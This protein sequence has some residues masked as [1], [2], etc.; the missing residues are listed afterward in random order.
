VDTNAWIVKLD[1]GLV[2]KLK[3][4]N[5][6]GLGVVTVSGLLLGKDGSI[7]AAGETETNPSPESTKKRQKTEALLDT[8]STILSRDDNVALPILETIPPTVTL[9]AKTVAQPFHVGD[10]R[11]TDLRRAMQSAGHTAEF[12][13]EGI[14]LVD[15]TVAVRKSTTGRVEVESVGLPV[16]DGGVPQMG[17][18]GTFYAVRKVIYDG[19]AV[20]AGA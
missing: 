16:V 7:E 9:S 18:G 17:M 4:Q 2:K 10:I 3:W 12:R 11:L 20:V 5:V 1:E 19:L 8:T 15:G 14:L 6:R 13:G